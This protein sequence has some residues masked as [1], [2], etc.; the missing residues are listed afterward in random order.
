M[1]RQCGRAYAPHWTPAIKHWKLDIDDYPRGA[2]QLSLDA[3]SRH[4]PLYPLHASLGARFV[5]FGGWEMPVRYG[6]IIEEAK[7]VRDRAGLFDVSHMGRVELTGPGAADLLN[8]VLSVD[9]PSIRTGRARYCVICSEEGGIIDDCIVYRLDAHRFL[10]VPNASNTSVVLDWLYRWSPNRDTV[11]IREVTAEI[12]MI[13]CQGPSAVRIVQALT[14]TDLSAVR[15]FQAITAEV[16]GAECLLARTGYTGEDGF[17]V[18]PSSSEAEALW[19]SLSDL[20]AASCGL[21]SRDVLRLE[22]GLLLHGNDMDASI[23]PYEAGLGR[24]VNPDR[25]GY[26]AGFALRKIRDAG[27]PRTICGFRMI[28][29]GIARPEHAILDGDTRIGK[30]T[31]G[32][33]SPTLDTIIGLGYVPTAYSEPGTRINIEIRGRPVDAEVTTLPFYRRSRST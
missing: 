26:V 32:G 16:N 18:M 15:P 33:P 24:F 4:T 27:T 23:N 12:A 20:G 5:S 13:A 25:E 28:G 10:L 14:E 7:A 11:E 22:A 31:S 30:V 1:V 9:V 8:S 17:E 29:R 21:G 19:T 6:S 2:N 3:P